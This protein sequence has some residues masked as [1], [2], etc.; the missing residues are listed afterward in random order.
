M[1]SIGRQG[2]GLIRACAMLCGAGAIAWSIFTF[3]TFSRERALEADVQ[4]IL[5]GE[6]YSPAQLSVL[7]DRLSESPDRQLRPSV[8]SNLAVIRLR[9][10][11]EDMAA[12][13]SKPD[14]AVVGE[15]A[16]SID[17]M[18]SDNPTNA[19]LWLIKFWLPI[20]QSDN[21]AV[22]FNLLRTS[23][24]MGPNEVWI[25][26]RRNPL[27]LSLFAQMPDDLA[28]RSIV[29]FAGLVRSGLYSDAAS[30]LAGPGLPIGQRLL[31]GLARVDEV[32]RYR[33]ARVL[34]ANDVQGLTI[35]G[36]KEFGVKE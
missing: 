4:R 25:A 12:G 13:R 21:A 24:L 32:S 36:I 11:E 30:I 34:E 31:D 6:Q 35:P 17:A 16:N 8:R 10:V 2:D 33:F 28:S 14:A 15:L 22:D 29:E 18:L 19:F 23:Y 3:P 27:A 5:T 20:Q 26:L 7:R 1:S 9:L